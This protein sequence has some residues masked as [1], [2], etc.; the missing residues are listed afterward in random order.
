VG[1]RS[2]PAVQDHARTLAPPVE[3]EIRLAL[4]RIREDPRRPDLDVR[5]LRK[6]APYLFF[7]ARVR[8]YRIVYGPRGGTTYVYRIQ[9]RSDGYEWLDTFD[10]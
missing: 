1:L 4:D 10:P 9:H 7:R 8:H 2:A 6:D 5:V 3:R